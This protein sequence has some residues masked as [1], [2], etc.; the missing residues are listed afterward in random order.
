MQPI[1]LFDT[2]LRLGP[3]VRMPMS[4][5]MFSRGPWIGGVNTFTFSFE[6]VRE[7]AIRELPDVLALSKLRVH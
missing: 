2:F 7:V 1:R 6:N 3:A 4:G 5:V